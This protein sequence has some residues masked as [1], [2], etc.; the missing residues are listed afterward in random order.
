MAG[1]RAVGGR[2]RWLVVAGGA[3]ELGWLALWPLGSGFSRAL[4]FTALYLAE[5]PP[6]RWLNDG[7]LGLVD[8]LAPGLQPTRASMALLAVFAGALAVVGVAYLLAV[9]LLQRGPAGRGG[10]AVVLGFAGL[11]QVTL[12][13]QPNVYTTDPF[14]YLTYGYIAGVRGLNPYVAAP[15]AFPEA[16]LQGWIHPLWQH[17]P[18]VYGPLWERAAAWL[19]AA[20]QPLRAT[21]QVLALRLLMN[22]VHLANLALLW[23]LLGAWLPDDRRGSARLAGFALYAWNPLVLF[24][25]A[26]GAHNDALMA[27]FLLLALAPLVVRRE[28]H[29]TGAWLAAVALA[30]LAALVK[31]TGGL[32]GLFMAAAALVRLPAWGSRLG[33]VGGAALAVAGAGAALGW[34]WL[35]EPSAWATLL[36]AAGGRHYLNSAPDLLALTL[37]DHVLGGRLDAESARALSRDLVR[38]A[39][40]TGF[41]A[42]LLWELWR[43]WRAAGDGARA[44]VRAAIEAGARALLLLPLVVLG[45]VVAWYF[46]W[47]LALAALLGW[48]SGLARVAVGYAALGLVVFNV[49]DYWYAASGGATMPGALLLA[50]VVLP[51]LVALAPN[52]GRLAWHAGRG[53]VARGSGALLP[54]GRADAR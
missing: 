7:L 25:T 37:A 30:G 17:Q 43:V 50:F 4:D 38:A 14:S 22:A 51:P 12:L 35:A 11:F 18:S 16:P 29:P 5:R 40:R 3:M 27:T 47:P 34:P 19:A 10:W 13:L 41:V 21:D 36:G 20:V 24:E 32:L 15:A 1:G 46:T 6:L 8:A 39:S 53:D 48:G 52:A 28:P 2:L 31:F 45:W 54:A 26:A 49:Q 9:L 44:A 23:R 33:V 42:Y